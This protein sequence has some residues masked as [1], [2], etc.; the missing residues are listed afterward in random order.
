[1]KL[2]LQICAIFTL[3]ITLGY[4][5][6]PT[7]VR[8]D[9]VVVSLTPSS[10]VTFTVGDPADLETL[11]HYNFQALFEDIITKLENRD[12][13]ALPGVP[14]SSSASTTAPSSDTEDWNI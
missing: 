10:K 9:T 2:R 8:K 11:K 7:A 6:T 14:P 5:Q 13:T 3:A 12:T 1:M 4:A